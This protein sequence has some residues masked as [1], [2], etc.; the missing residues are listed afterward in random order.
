MAKF[1]KIFKNFKLSDI[2]QGIPKQAIQKLVFDV[3]EKSYPENREK[4]PIFV[5]PGLRYAHKKL[6]F[7]CKF[8]LKMF[9]AV[10]I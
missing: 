4:N 7:V 1:S 5:Y 6:S 10:E 8:F 9:V 2:D 3:F